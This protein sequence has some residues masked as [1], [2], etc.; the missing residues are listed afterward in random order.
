MAHDSRSFLVVS[1]LVILVVVIAG[2]EGVRAPQERTTQPGYFHA[3]SGPLILGDAS[4]QAKGVA[5][6]RHAP[7]ADIR[8]LLDDYAEEDGSSPAVDR[9]IDVRGLNQTLDERWPIK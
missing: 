4:L 9:R 7:M 6:H 2:L 1:V 5:A 3:L 8:R